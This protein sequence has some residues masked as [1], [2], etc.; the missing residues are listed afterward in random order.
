MANEL[1]QFGKRLESLVDGSANRRVLTAAGTAGKKSALDAA[2]ADLGGDMAMS[3]LRRGRAKL[4]A[5]YDFEGDST[6]AINMR[7]PWRLADQGRRASGKIAPKRGRK[8]VRTPF[9]PRR[10]SSY[11]PSRGLD[12][13]QDAVRDAEQSVPKAAAEQFFDEVARVMRLT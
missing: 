7:G 5:G 10:S 6:V 2:R 3:N 1:T 11:G 9:G 13:Y 12:T 8:A 4:S